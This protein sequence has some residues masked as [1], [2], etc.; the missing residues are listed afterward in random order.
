MDEEKKN[1]VSIRLQNVS[2]KLQCKNR[3]KV[4]VSQLNAFIDGGSVFGIL[5]GSGSGKTSLLNIIS[6]RYDRKVI[7]VEGRVLFQ[8]VDGKGGKEMERGV[9]YVMQNDHLMSHLTP[10][11]TLEFVAN[12]REIKSSNLSISVDKVILDLG[13]KECADVLI[14]GDGVHDK[15]AISGGQRRRLSIGIQMITGS[16]ILCADEPTSGLDAFTA[17]TVIDA[18]VNLAKNSSRRTTVVVSLHQPRADVFNRLDSVLL[19][20]RGGHAVY[21]GKRENMI[22][23]FAGMGYSCPIHSN[24]ADYFVDLSSVNS[25]SI[26][27]E[28]IDVE[29]VRKLVQISKKNSLYTNDENDDSYKDEGSLQVRAA[30]DEMTY[31]N[32]ILN[33]TCLDWLNQVYT[34]LRRFSLNDFRDSGNIR[35]VFLQAVVLGLIRMFV[36]W[37][38]DE[39][40]ASVK[41]RTGLMHMTLTG[42]PYILLILWCYRYTEELRVFDRELQDNLYV[43][44]A[45]FTAHLLSS[46]PLL[47]LAPIIYAIPIYLGARLRPGASHI[48]MFFGVNVMSIFIING[49]AW[50]ILYL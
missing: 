41:S 6:N 10:R 20:S 17:Y 18:L 35:G 4:L 46:L 8:C 19:L 48:I 28:Q 32:R 37:Q 3:S 33:L 50:V 29:R 12:L 2:V 9:G 31:S 5:G 15:R 40:F 43:P 34:L 21:C 7:H 27:V 16:P 26:S 25:K 36:F 47:I 38:L 1:S 13:L 39:D 42:L 14:G 24:P 11:E 44:S 49:L 22:E 23:Y 45:Y 30:I